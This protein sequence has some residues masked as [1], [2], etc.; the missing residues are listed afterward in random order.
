M[1]ERSSQLGVPRLLTLSL[2]VALPAGKPHR[3]ALVDKFI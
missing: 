3:C 2:R 1:N